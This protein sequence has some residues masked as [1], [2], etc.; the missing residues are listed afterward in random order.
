MPVKE[1]SAAIGDGGF[2]SPDRHARERTFDVVGELF[3]RTISSFR[4]SAEGLHDDGVEVSAQP[5]MQ[6]RWLQP[7]AL[8]TNQCRSDRNPRIA[9]A[10]FAFFLPV[11][12]GARLF[13]IG[14]RNQSFQFE[15]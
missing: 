3:D 5:T 9:L 11:H 8:L 2:A 12:G 14:F 15:Q 1:S 13:G 6:F 10:R 7:A 4:L